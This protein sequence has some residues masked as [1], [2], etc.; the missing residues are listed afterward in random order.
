MV[1]FRVNLLSLSTTKA[2]SNDQLERLLA[3]AHPRD[4]CD[5]HPYHLGWVVRRASTKRI[6]EF[7]Q[8][9]SLQHRRQLRRPHKRARLT[10]LPALLRIQF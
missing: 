8:R 10:S 5:L 7:M 9:H 4:D 6:H 1:F 3:S 2:V